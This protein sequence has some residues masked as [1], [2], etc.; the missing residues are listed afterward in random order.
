MK[1]AKEWQ[2]LWAGEDFIASGEHIQAIQSDA[3]KA[4]LLRAAQVCRSER[5]KPEQTTPAKIANAIAE[6]LARQIENESKSHK[7][8]IKEAK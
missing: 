5:A 2:E 8:A 6:A 3:Y 7:E 4:G 1:T